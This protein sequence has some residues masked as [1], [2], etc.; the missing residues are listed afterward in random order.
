MPANKLA[1]ALTAVDWNGNVKE[2]LK[3]S[4]ACEAIEAANWRLA[5]WAKQFEQVDGTNPA[6]CF[7]REMQTSGH[8]VAALAALG[9]YKSAAASIRSVFEAAL[10][11]SY[12]RTHPSELATL[13]RGSDFY[14]GRREI[15]DFHKN[16]TVDFAALEQR[17]GFLSKLRPWWAYISAIIHGQVPGKWVDHK[18]IAEIKMIG[19]TLDALVKAFADGEELVRLL[20]LCTVARELWDGFSSPS[21]KALLAGLHGD[22]KAALALDSA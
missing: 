18:S 7:I 8:N 21:K 2:F 10:Y 12:F 9:L 19:L 15:I 4:K 22:V 13:A 14:L 5:I 3:R 6:I 17:L 20:F 11:Y 1:A 16:H